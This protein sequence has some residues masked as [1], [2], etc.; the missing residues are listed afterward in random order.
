MSVYD[1][2]HVSEQYRRTHPI[3]PIYEETEHTM[4][5]TASTGRIQDIVRQIR[6]AALPFLASNHDAVSARDASTEASAKH[7]VSRETIMAELAKLSQGGQWTSGEVKHAS[8]VAANLSN[9]ES[10]KALATFIGQCKLAMAPKVRAYVGDFLALRD[11]AWEAEKAAYAIDDETPTPLKKAFARGYHVFVALMSAAEDGR[12]ID[13]VPELLAFAEERDPDHD[14]KKIHKRLTR[15][16]DELAAFNRDFPNSDIQLCV[17]TLNEITEA[18]LIKSAVPRE[19]SAYA[20]PLAPIPPVVAARVDA[21]PQ[22]AASE[23]PKDE[24]E[25]DNPTIDLLEDALSI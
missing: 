15:I 7:T 13:S 16:A 23:A 3:T 1:D 17:E 25:K 2:Y 12:V 22:E 9:N 6:G 8:Q 14:P 11:L 21:Q 10:E 20:G 19:R 18:Q 4:T 5:P 24:E